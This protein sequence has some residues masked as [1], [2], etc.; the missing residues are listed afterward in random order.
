MT[1]WPTFPIDR[2]QWALT[3]TDEDDRKNWAASGK[4]RSV[5]SLG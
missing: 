2:P 4:P 3:S 5:P 1:V